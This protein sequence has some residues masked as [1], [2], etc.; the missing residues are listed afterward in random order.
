MKDDLR[1][2]AA[3]ISQLEP[4]RRRQPRLPVAPATGVAVVVAAVG[5][6]TV[7]SRQRPLPPP[8]AQ[9]NYP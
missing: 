4:R 2:P 6:Y 5:A 3:G 8:T 1:V 9:A 7:W